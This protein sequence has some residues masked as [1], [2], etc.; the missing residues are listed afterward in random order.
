M[1]ETL[2]KA[3]D[4]TVQEPVVIE[5]DI[6]PQGFLHRLLQKWKW[7][8][9]KRKFVI[10]PIKMGSLI[11]ISKLMLSIDMSV[12]DM[13]NLLESNYKAIDKHASTMA[14]IVAVAIQNNKHQPSE[15][16]VEFVLNNFTSHE[17]RMVASM[18]LKQMDVTSFMS[19]IISIKG[20]NVLE[21]QAA[22]AP[23]AK[24]NEVS[25]LTQ[26]RGIAPGTLSAAS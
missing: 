11:R 25:P 12:F 3:A 22:T 21:M 15:K 7:L 26:G 19:S 6:N 4:A 5:V 2:S 10:E 17:L 16:L 14:R 8:P 18:V 20:T 23:G 24:E 13:R 9:R 1:T